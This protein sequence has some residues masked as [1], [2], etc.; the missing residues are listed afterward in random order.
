MPGRRRSKRRPKRDAGHNFVEEIGLT[1]QLRPLSKE[2][3][4][5]PQNRSSWNRRGHKA[6]STDKH[7]IAHRFHGAMATRTRPM[8]LR[9]LAG[10]KSAWPKPALSIAPPG[11]LRLLFWSEGD[12]YNRD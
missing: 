5:V 6:V 4:T 10:P 2:L 8:F 7:V 12:F 1:L 3:E 9:W 11:S